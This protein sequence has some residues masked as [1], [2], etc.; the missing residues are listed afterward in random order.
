[1]LRTNYLSVTL[2]LKKDLYKY[3]VTI[4]PAST[5]APAL[6]NIRK[7][8]QVYNIL[9]GGERDFQVLR[10]GFATDYAENLIT[11][12]RLYEQSLPHKRYEVVYRNELEGPP[13]DNEGTQPEGRKVLGHS[14][15]QCHG[16]HFGA[17]Q[18]H[19]V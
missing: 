9:F 16:T 14:D 7:R 15:T 6:K 13:D 11:C 18:I 5:E 17:H 2:D 1:M 8:R 10:H 12:G 19:R 3:D 4:E